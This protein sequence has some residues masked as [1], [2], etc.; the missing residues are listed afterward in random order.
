MAQLKFQA[1]TGMHDILPDTQPLWKKMLEVLEEI[2][3]FYGFERIDLPI[4][5]QS[6]L[7]LK[8]TGD[9][10]EV[11]QKQMYGLRTR[12]GDELTLR[13][14]GTPSVVRAYLEH[15]M[16]NMPMPVKLYYAGPMFRYERPQAG[17]FR[18]FNQFGVEAI[19]EESPITDAEIIQMFAVMLESL[20]IKAYTIHI[21]SIGNLQSRAKYKKVLKDY[22]RPRIKQVCA[23]C[24]D[25][26]KT[27]TLRVLYFKNKKFQRL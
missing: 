20:K 12:G 22:Y 2:A 5:E 6:E 21:N 17:R 27:N 9:Q 13:P 18:Q 3:Q 11:V 23:E 7:F 19:G 24:R 16:S 26:I 8:G 10:S 1:P 25:R 4:L 14:E 15:G